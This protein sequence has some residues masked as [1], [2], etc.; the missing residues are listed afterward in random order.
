MGRQQTLPQAMDQ[1]GSYQYLCLRSRSWFPTPHAAIREWLFLARARCVVRFRL[2][3]NLTAANLNIAQ[4]R[5]KILR[6]FDR[7]IVCIIA[8]V[9][10][11]CSGFDV[12]YLGIGRG[13]GGLIAYFVCGLGS[14]LA[15]FSG[16]FWARVVAVSWQMLMLTY[17]LLKARS[18]QDAFLPLAWI[19]PAMI[20]LAVTAVVSFL[21][22]SQNSNE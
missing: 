15:L 17:F 3:G 8:A 20:Y 4:R 11:F 1:R 9:Q 6:V 12:L 7:I 22:K 16:R 19:A 21:R 18:S 14:A 13:P 5:L 2:S 10:M